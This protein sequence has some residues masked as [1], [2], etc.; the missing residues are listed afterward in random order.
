MKEGLNE[1]HIDFSFDQKKWQMY[2]LKYL[3]SD[4]DAI[5][6]LENHDDLPK[7]HYRR[8]RRVVPQYK[9]EI[10]TLPPKKEGKFWLEESKDGFRFTKDPERFETAEQ[11]TR[12]ITVRTMAGEGSPFWRLYR[13]IG[14]L[15]DDV[16][17]RVYDE[18]VMTTIPADRRLFF[19]MRRWLDDLK[20]ASFLAE[21]ATDK[22]Y[23][24][25]WSA[26]R[27]KKMKEKISDLE[28][29]LDIQARSSWKG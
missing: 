20:E 6:W 5:E 1:Y 19:A 25:Q 17:V 2:S 4:E 15:G 24:A 22:K 26:A 23:V 29:W 12:Y 28:R 8:V 13:D 10:M 21:Y 9:V 27:A 3:K 7:N 11:A 14:D 16:L 18:Q